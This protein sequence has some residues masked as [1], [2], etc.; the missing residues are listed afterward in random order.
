ML[1][2]KTQRKYLCEESIQDLLREPDLRKDDSSY[3]PDDNAD[4]S[5]SDH[6]SEASEVSNHHLEP[7]YDPETP[8]DEDLSINEKISYHQCDPQEPNKRRPECPSI[9]R[10]T[11]YVTLV[12]MYQNQIWQLLFFLQC[13]THKPFLKKKRNHKLF[14]TV[15]AQKEILTHSIISE[16]LCVQETYKSLAICIF[17]NLLDVCGVT[18][19]VVWMSLHPSWNLGKQNNRRMFLVAVAESLIQPQIERRPRV[20]LEK[21]L[22]TIAPFMPRA[23]RPLH[24]LRPNYRRAL[25][26]FESAY[27]NLILRTIWG[28]MHQLGFPRKLIN[29]C[30]IVS[31][32]PKATVKLGKI[33]TENFKLEKG[34]RQGDGLAPLLFNI[35]LHI[36][37]IKSEVQINGTIFNKTQQ[38]LGYAD[39]VIITGR[40]IQDVEEALIALDS[41]AGI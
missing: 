25:K 28:H 29:V 26:D 17:M 3:E 30:R 4:N 12:S 10:F 27:D 7:Q 11:K 13:T 14:F 37:I 20:G 36:A 9:F 34:T 22:M 39:D 2:W 35:A 33:T 38:I 40:R 31:S 32:E 1:N 6:Q 41:E 16:C 8:D 18:A 23:S 19:F 5:K 24:Q 15:I 21:K